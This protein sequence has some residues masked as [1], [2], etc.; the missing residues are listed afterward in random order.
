MN[1]EAVRHK[2]ARDLSSLKAFITSTLNS[3]DT[4]QPIHKDGLYDLAADNF[5]SHIESSRHFIMF[6]APWCGH[7]KRLEPVWQD[8]A[9]LYEPTDG[10]S[11]GV[12]IGRVSIL[13]ITS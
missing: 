3:D 1:K 2:G 4:R 5:E 12:K 13:F 7:C 10:N 11:N 6:Y 8:L 9:R